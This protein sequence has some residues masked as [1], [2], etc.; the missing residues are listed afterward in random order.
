MTPR[1]LITVLGASLAVGCGWLNPPNELASAARTG[2]LE[3][4][5][6]LVAAGADVNFMSAFGNTPLSEAARMGFTR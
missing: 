2:D 5:D 4:I 6:R 3:T 1:L